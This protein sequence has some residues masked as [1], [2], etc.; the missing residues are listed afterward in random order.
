V[1]VFRLVLALGG[2]SLL[3]VTLAGAGAG[4]STPSA[5]L[6]VETAPASFGG[7]VSLEV[8]PDVDPAPARLTFY[9]PA[10]YGLDTSVAPGTS[11]GVVDAIYSTDAKPLGFIQGLVKTGDP[12]S[13]PSDPAAQACAPGSHAAVWLATFMAAG[14]PMTIRFYVDPTTGGET[15]LGA[16]ELIACFPSPYVPVEQGGAP[17]G[18]RFAA[19]YVGLVEKSGSVFKT[20][21][22]GT[23]TWRVFVTPYVTGS[24]TLD[25]AATFEA[26]TRVLIPHVLTEHVRF[27]PKTKTMLVTGHLNALGKPRR[28]VALD[29]AAGPPKAHILAYWGTAHTRADGSYSIR[30]RIRVRAR[31]YKLDVYVFGDAVP[32]SCKAPSTAPAGCVDE[33]ISPPWTTPVRV[34]V[35]KKRKH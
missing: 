27:L 5:K 29:V 16:F 8:D 31:A 10:G 22:A 21:S 33:N 12:S 24:A 14:Q 11:I 2:V 18:L 3:A 25:V 7:G 1:R 34:T 9:V 6:T 30:K 35:P 26:R 20:P 13:L 17:G 23:F 4:D 15:S 19:F 32:G 28:K